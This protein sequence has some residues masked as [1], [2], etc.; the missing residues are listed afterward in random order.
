MLLFFKSGRFALLIT[1][2]LHV[3]YSVLFFFF[4]FC[5]TNGRPKLLRVAWIG[6]DHR[7]LW[8]F[9]LWSWLQLQQP[10]FST[11]ST[12]MTQ[13][14]SPSTSF[15]S[16]PWSCRSSTLACYKDRRWLGLGSFWVQRTLPIIPTH[17]SS[18]PVVMMAGSSE[19]PWTIAE[20]GFHRRTTPRR[21]SRPLRSAGRRWCRKGW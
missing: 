3:C 16:N 10:C 7:G 2:L 21:R 17:T 4:F 11:N 1:L 9:S 12:P 6:G 14:L 13:L 20:L 18:T 15:H 5:T 8:V 19:S